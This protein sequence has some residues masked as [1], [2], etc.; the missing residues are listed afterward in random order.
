MRSADVIIR[1]QSIRITAPDEKLAFQCRQYINEH[2]IPDLSSVYEHIF[3]QSNDSGQYL[4]IDK[5]KVDMGSMRASDLQNNFLELLE[6]KLIMELKNQFEHDDREDKYEQSTDRPSVAAEMSESITY[7]TEAEQESLALLQFLQT[8][9]FPWWYA[10]KH[11]KA[12]AQLLEDLGTEE[13]KRFILTMIA[14]VSRL[15]GSYAVASMVKRLFIHLS[16]PQYEIYFKDVRDLYSEPK[17]QINMQTILNQK[18]QVVRLFRMRECDFYEHAV[19]CLLLHNDKANFLKMFLTHLQEHFSVNSQEL[20]D[21]PAQS[22]ISF[23][24][25]L[26]AQEARSSSIPDKPVEPEESIYISNAGLIILHPFLPAL[27]EAIG[28]LDDK[29]QFISIETQTRAAVLLYYLQCGSGA[30]KEWEMPLNKILCGMGT[31]DLIPDNIRLTNKETKE[32]DLLLEGVVEHWTALRA[33]S[34]DALQTSFLIR[35][36]KIRF[37]EGFWVL[38]VERSGIDILLDRLPWGIGTIKFPWIKELISVEW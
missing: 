5:L 35:E 9:R 12:P 18:E 36:G 19:L 21:I 38:Q 27:F 26:E 34:I 32:A 14:S 25:S 8:G 1:K 28:F 4:T 16:P 6:E 24:I 2:I 23:F 22:P 13:R 7:S 20:E 29:Y 17:V 37:K 31:A 30:Y 33:C 15:R 11:S 10:K 3:Y